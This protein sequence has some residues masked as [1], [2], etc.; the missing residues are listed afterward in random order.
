MFIP[1]A[2]LSTTPHARAA[3]E[4]FS[5][6]I[7]IQSAVIFAL[8][9][10]LPGC[11]TVTTDDHQSIVVTSDPLGATCRVREGG[12]IVAVVNA[13]P[14]TILVG[15][16]RHDIGIDCTRPG[17]YP[18]A[19]VL[20]PHFQGWTFGNILYGGSLGLLVD[21]SSGAMNEYPHW[22]K[23]LMKPLSPRADPER[24][25][26]A[27]AARREALQNGDVYFRQ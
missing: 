1:P 9:L 3:A 24:L 21:A 2:T 16:S 10:A 17:Y 12:A 25:S 19:A 20:E 22:V 15:K 18:G 27:E 6:R 23:V 4:P 26:E 5:S 13:T 11:A 8:V 7:L 14:A